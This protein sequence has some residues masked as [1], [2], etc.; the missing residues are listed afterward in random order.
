MIERERKGVEQEKVRKR[1]DVFGHDATLLL[2]RDTPTSSAASSRPIRMMRGIYS[3]S[4]AFFFRMLE[5]V[6]TTMQLFL[7]QRSSRLW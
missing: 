2:C 6:L 4:S 1:R 3:S 7:H 5:S